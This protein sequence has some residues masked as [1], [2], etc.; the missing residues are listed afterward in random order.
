[1]FKSVTGYSGTL[2][3]VYICVFHFLGNFY[4]QKNVFSFKKK[5]KSL[6]AALLGTL[7]L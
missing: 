2:K 1:M 6:V 3:H 4:D 7:W 5:K